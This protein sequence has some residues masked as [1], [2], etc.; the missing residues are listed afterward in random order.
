MI[1]PIRM[2]L[3]NGALIKPCNECKHS[4]YDVGPNK[5]F[6]MIA[7]NVVDETPAACSDARSNPALCGLGGT[8]WEPKE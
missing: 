8:H 6:C 4:E 5:H 1:E 2:R 3:P 7:L